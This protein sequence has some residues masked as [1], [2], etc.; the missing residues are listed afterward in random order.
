MGTYTATITVSGGNSVS[1]SFNVSFTVAPRPAYG[2]SLDAGAAF[3]FPEAVEGYGTQTA[4]T[5]TVENVGLNDTGV[6]TIGKSGANAANFTV[7]ASSLDSIAMSG[8]GAFTVVP[9]TEL[10]VGT[11]TATIT[12]SGGNG[13]SESF[14]VSFRV[15]P[16]PVYGVSLDAGTGF[17]FPAAI[18]GYGTQTARSVTV[19][20]TGNQATGALTIAKSGTNAASFTVSATNLTD[21]TVGGNDSFTVVPDTGLEAGTYT[22]TI[23]VSGGNSISA[24]LDVS[25]TVVAAAPVY[26]I[27]LSETGTYAFLAAVAGY[28]AQTARTVTV[29]NTGNRAT[30][31][32]TVGKS[33]AGAANFTVSKTSLN[34]IAVSG[35]DTFTVVPVTGLEEG[36][37]TATI[38][39][40]G[41]NDISASF[42]V[43]FTVVTAAP[44]YSVSLSETGTYAFLAAVAGYGA[45]TA[46]TVTVTNTGNR[47]TG[48]LT[49]GKSGAGAA[50]FTVSK[51]SLN[52]IA[53]SGSDT[54]T[55]VPVTGLGA[56]TYT[57]TITV[58]GGNGISASFNVS[59]TVGQVN[60]VTVT[61]NADGGAPAASTAQTGSG[62]TVSLPANPVKSG[63]TFSGWYTA[64]NGGGTEFTAATPVTVDAT[65]YAKWLSANANLVSLTVSP[66]WLE[67]TFYSG[68]TAYTVTVPSATT[69]ITVTATAADFGKATVQ[70][71]ADNPVVGLDPGSNSVRIKVTAEDGITT[72]NYTIT[73]TR[74]PLSANANLG[75]LMV[76]P[77]TLDPAFSATTTAYTVLVP[78][79]TS[80][81]DVTA[82][83]ADTKAALNQNP[84]NSVNLSA[85][86]TAIAI[87][88]TAENGTATKTYTVTVK[89]IAETNAVNV[90]ITMAEEVIDLTRNTENDL[91][92]EA[93]NSLRLTAPEGYE[94]YTWQVDGNAGQYIFISDR[95]IELNANWY[96]YGTHSALL[97]FEKDG[98]TYG[99]EV[100]FK[101]VR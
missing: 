74:T 26:R 8:S 67:E 89:R 82:A 16:V 73:V 34:S 38:T 29:T 84:P 49:V 97:E 69:S 28:G 90:A 17:A 61:F 81:I 2:I 35:T 18:A 70:Y 96:S 40:R 83:V 48:A 87:T 5:V 11:Y 88:V 54:F 68:N 66:G 3:A 55:V 19:T 58:S 24:S 53:V 14:N 33:G 4:K 65:V 78:D 46:R 76:S 37:Y 50:N 51:T 60:T 85:E 99:R 31:A 91:S 39:V 7:S 6:L 92:H 95:V 86:S 101:V 77:G 36:T 45:Q 71:P 20:N 59:F 10:G 32:L 43:S 47:A 42:N 100:L 25:F 64:A 44:V 72:K 57:A 30:G 75:S 56:G 22:A 62:G 15:T 79:T 98:V 12:V 63:Y 94:K 41:G 80:S 93:D 52:S 13:I 23:T 1:A 21:I 9:V 27:S